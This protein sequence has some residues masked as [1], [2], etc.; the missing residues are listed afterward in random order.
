MK[1]KTCN[2]RTTSNENMPHRRDATC[3]AFSCWELSLCACWLLVAAERP[4][5]AENIQHWAFRPVQ[6]QPLPGVKKTAWPGNEID[7]FILARLEERGLAPAPRADKRTL[8]RRLTFD[9]IGLPPTPEEIEAFLRDESPRA[10]A[11]VVDRLLASPHYGE[12]WGRHW[13]DVARY[14]DSNGMDENLVQAHA[15][16]YRDYVI[17]A[18]NRDMPFDRF[19]REQIAGDLLDEPTNETLIAT[20]FLA[21]GPKMLAEDDPVKMQ[22]DVVDEQIDTVGK[23]FLGLTLGCARCHDHKFD[24][25]STADYYGLAGIFKSTQVMENYKVVARWFERPIGSAAETQRLQAHR[26]QIAALRQIVAD[27]VNAANQ[28]LLAEA[29]PQAAA[30]VE[31][32]LELNRRRAALR[33]L[34]LLMQGAAPPAGTIVIEAENYDRGNVKR[35][36]AAYGQKIGVIYNAGP[37][38]NLAEYD[39]TLPT[40]G[41]YQVELRLAAAESRP[42]ELTVNS[43]VISSAAA[44]LVTGSWY[45]DTQTWSVEGVVALP[46]G[47]STLRLRREGPFP[48]FDKLALVPRELPSGVTSLVAATPEQLANER[49]LNPIFLGQWADYL[50]KHATPSGEAL[51]KLAAD[52]QGPFAVPMAAERYY[53]AA[54]QEELRK[55]REQGAALE[56]SLPALPEA[57]GAAEGKVENVR[58]HL[59]GS[60]WTL[61]AE[62]PRGFPRLLAGERP[63]AIPPTQSGRRQLAEWLTRPE[64]PLTA[65]VLVNRVWHWHFGVGLVPSTDNFGA[66]G[67]APSHPALLDWLARTFIE[68]GWSIKALHRRIVLSSTYQMSTAWDSAAAG[69]DPGNRLLWRFRRQRLDAES[70]RDALL[71]VGGNLDS[72]MGGTLLE[73]ANR[74]Y[75]PGYPNGVYERYDFPRRSVYLP[76]LRSMLYGV[77]QAFDFADPSTPNGQR[78]STTVAPQALFALNGKLMADQSRAFA[79]RLLSAASMDDYKRVRLAYLQALARP[80]RGEETASALDLVCRLET[81]WSRQLPDAQ[82]RRLRAWQ[83]LARALLSCNEFVYVE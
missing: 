29:R 9:L 72:V 60:H 18:F 36:F 49:K 80:P 4:A 33:E 22:M 16:R 54:A 44:A 50:A 37:L 51:A 34:K 48:H 83:G 75:V 73:G 63:P 82:E 12:R 30:Y 47:K 40:A 23:T 78:D 59:R 2:T 6:R 31:A 17:G 70:L 38:P 81:E 42:V 15:W 62:A 45:P 64:H 32:A 71:A 76:V 35:D 77:F 26:Q 79:A 25:I 43:Q 21:L 65:R 68:D 20:G 10:W 55:L 24:P 1:T 61:G 3:W 13:L 28:A 74:G 39:I 52:P 46:A 27:K 69:V 66:L 67:D 57:M 19:V 8:L 14:A 7:R 41:T 56:K 53:G 5:A 11:N 58:I